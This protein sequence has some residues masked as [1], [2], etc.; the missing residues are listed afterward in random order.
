MLGW[1]GTIP[2]DTAIPALCGSHFCPSRWSSNCK[3]SASWPRAVPGAQCELYLASEPNKGPETVLTALIWVVLCFF[4]DDTQEQTNKSLLYSGLGH[5]AVVPVLLSAGRHSLCKEFT[6]TLPWFQAYKLLCL[7]AWSK[8][9]LPHHTK[10][11]NP[12]LTVFSLKRKKRISQ[13]S[14]SQNEK[15]IWSRREIP[16]T[17]HVPYCRPACYSLRFCLSLQ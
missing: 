12:R 8:L 11:S 4:A 16:N 14:Q 1:W 10:L 2:H 3:G 6:K 7:Q 13:L 17:F 5:H 15:W 9:P